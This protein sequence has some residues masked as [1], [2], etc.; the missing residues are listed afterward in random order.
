MHKVIHFAGC[1]SANTRPPLAALG[2]WEMGTACM[3]MLD[4]GGLGACFPWNFLEM[5]CS[6]I[7][8]GTSLGQKQSHDS[9]M[10]RSV[11]HPIL[12]VH[13]CMC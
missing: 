3:S 10:T 11:L 7:A 12:V 2:D 8:S 13:I 4:L 9:Y 1:I 6:E 5:R